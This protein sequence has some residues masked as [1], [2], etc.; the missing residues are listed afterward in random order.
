MKIFLE[1]PEKSSRREVVEV[2]EHHATFSG[3]CPSCGTS[4]FRVSGKNRRVADDREYRAD[5]SCV[6]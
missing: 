1:P 4:P 3:A 6:D 5:G 2:F